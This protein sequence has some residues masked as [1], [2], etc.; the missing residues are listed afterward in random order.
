MNR[1]RSEIRVHLELFPQSKEALLW[2]QTC[3]GIVPARA[4]HGA[5]EN[6][7][8]GFAKLDSFGGQRRT[9]GIERATTDQS[10]AQFQRVIPPLGHRVEHADALGY[11]L[12]PDPVAGEQRN[13]QRVHTRLVWVDS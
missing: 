11:D 5:E 1:Y 13:R 9:A 6:G 12:R 7:V 4:A 10:L 3:V 2:T 8:G